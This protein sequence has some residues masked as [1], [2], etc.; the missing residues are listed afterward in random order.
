MTVSGKCH[1]NTPNLPNSTPSTPAPCGVSATTCRM[2]RRGGWGWG[3]SLS[4][5]DIA[6]VWPPG[7]VYTG[8]P[9]P[10]RRSAVN[11]R[12]NFTQCYPGMRRL[13]YMPFSKAISLDHDH[14]CR[15]HTSPNGSQSRIPCH[16]LCEAD[17]TRGRFVQQDVF[18][19]WTIFHETTTRKNISSKHGVLDQTVLAFAK[20]AKDLPYQL[21]TVCP[22][23]YFKCRSMSSVCLPGRSAPPW[24]R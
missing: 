12:I 4:L 1:P 21:P 20:G 18:N 10:G 22:V 9:S 3:H 15:T 16:T 6:L 7:H 5:G 13:I 11:K 24:L 23:V 14:K 2:T 8:S 17:L 19:S